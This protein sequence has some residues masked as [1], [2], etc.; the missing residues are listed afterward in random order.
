MY[1]STIIWSSLTKPSAAH[2]NAAACSP[3]NSPVRMP[4][5]S[6]A[7]IWRENVISGAHHI[8]SPSPQLTVGCGTPEAPLVGKSHPQRCQV[9]AAS[10]IVDSRSQHA[11]IAFGLRAVLSRTMTWLILRASSRTVSTCGRVSIHLSVG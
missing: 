3:K 2:F 9:V 7:R 1:G 4:S 6:P 5:A 10:Q 8:S 11:P